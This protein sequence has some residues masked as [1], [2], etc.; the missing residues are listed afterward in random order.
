MSIQQIQNALIEDVRN[1]LRYYVELKWADNMGS[2]HFYTKKHK[3]LETALKLSMNYT[4]YYKREYKIGQII[5]KEIDNKNPH[6]K[7]NKN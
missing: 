4:N 1:N 3:I 7:I 6:I 2:I 5:I